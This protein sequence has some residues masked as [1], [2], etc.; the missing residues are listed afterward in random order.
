MQST[1]KVRLRPIALPP[2]HGSWGL[3]LEPIALGLLL[4][5]TAA[6]FSLG[7]G[8]FAAFL[9][10]RPFKVA[11]AQSGSG[12]STRTRVAVAFFGGYA[13]VAAAAFLVALSLSGLPPLTPLLCA[14]PFAGVFL[15]YDLRNQSRTWQ[16]ELAG[17]VAFAMVTAAI[18]IAGGWAAATALALSAVLVARNVSSI[19]YVRNRIRLERGKPYDSAVVWIVHTATLLAIV[20]LVGFGLLPWLAALPF[21]VLLGRAVIGL[22]VYRRSVT[23]K[24]IGF[25]ELGYGILTVLAVAVGHWIAVA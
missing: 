8:A 20:G 19:L 11:L 13:L 18:A 1:A 5:P 6:G 25:A 16:A 14:L 2:E 23:V 24:R 4:A 7:V 22:S 21:V 9:T 15:A 12:D 17:A 3:V 10:R